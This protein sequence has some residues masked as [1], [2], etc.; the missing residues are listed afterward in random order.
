MVRLGS[1]AHERQPKG[2]RLTGRIKDFLRSVTLR[3]GDVAEA[4]QIRRH[5]QPGRTGA[6]NQAVQHAVLVP[7]WGYIRRKHMS[8]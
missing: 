8:T 1:A 2:R 5:R 4:R 3:A 7:V 6:D